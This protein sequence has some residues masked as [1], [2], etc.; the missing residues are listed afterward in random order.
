MTTAE[1]MRRI[2]EFFGSGAR[3][4][5]DSLLPLFQLRLICMM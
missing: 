2:S 4:Y 1:E 3:T 5:G